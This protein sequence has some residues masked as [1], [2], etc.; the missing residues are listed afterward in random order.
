MYSN[1]WKDAYRET[2]MPK[3][4]KKRFKSVSRAKAA[5]KKSGKKL[6][7]TKP[8]SSYAK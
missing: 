8:K 3:V 2:A 5:A 7:Y 1:G 4:G 6:T